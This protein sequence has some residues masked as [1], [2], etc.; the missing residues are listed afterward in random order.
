MVRSI[1]P[2]KDRLDNSSSILGT[3]AKACSKSPAIFCYDLIMNR[4]V[5]QKLGKSGILQVIRG[6]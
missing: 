2:E 3:D 4:L 6:L 1:L 5:Q